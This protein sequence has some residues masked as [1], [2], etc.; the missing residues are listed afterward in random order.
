[1]ISREVSSIF[2]VSSFGPIHH[3][4]QYVGNIHMGKRSHYEKTKTSY[5]WQ[6]LSW[7]QK[8]LHS[9]ISWVYLLVSQLAPIV[10]RNAVDIYNRIDTPDFFAR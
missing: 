2:N 4:D 7:L 3:R 9:S 10:S 8:H 5:W 6:N 1:M